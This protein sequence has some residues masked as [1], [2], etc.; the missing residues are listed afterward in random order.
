MRLVHVVHHLK[1]SPFP[2]AVLLVPPLELLGEQLHLLVHRLV[3]HPVHRHLSI[4]L[5]IGGER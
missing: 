1:Y 3:Q 2:F 5:K 4:R